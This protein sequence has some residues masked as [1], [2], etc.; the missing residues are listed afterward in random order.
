MKKAVTE[1]PTTP[2][3]KSTQR[4]LLVDGTS[5]CYRA[6]YAIRNL[7]NSKGEPT[8]AIYGFI[9]MIRKLVEEMVPDYLAIAFDRKEPTFRHQRFKDYKAHRKPMP[10]DLVQQLEPIKNYCR[11]AGF[12]IFEEPGYEAD[13]LLGTL[14]KKGEKEKFDVFIVTGDKDFLQ[15]VSGHIKILNPHKEGLLYDTEA[16]RNRFDGIGPEKV[17]DIL[18]LMGDASDN[19][20]GVPGIGEKTALKLIQEFGTVE[21][22]LKHVT[23]LPSKSQQAVLQENAQI[24]LLSKELAT[25]DTEVPLRFSWPGLVPQKSDAEQ[26]ME[27]YKR[28]EFRSLLKDITPAGETRQAERRYEIIT[29]EKGFSRLAAKLEKAGAFSFDT[30]TTHED[31]MRAHLVGMSFSC[32]EFHAAYVPISSPNHAGTGIAMD[33]ALALIQPLLENENIKKCGQNIKYDWI[34]M[35]R[36]GVEI[37]GIDFDTMVASYLL[38]P[39]KLNHNL[40]DISL[41]YLGVRKI[42]TSALIGSG[43]NSAKKRSGSAANSGG[44]ITMAEVP[45]EKIAEYA[46]EDA[47]C[48]FRLKALFQA[49]LQE[50]NLTR[51]FEQVEMPLV[52]VLAKMEM[53]G[54]M[55]DT[56]LLAELSERFEK[57]L[58]RLTQEIY[59]QAGEEF[60]INSTKQLADILFVKLHLPVI[61]RTKTGYSTDVEVLEKLALGHELP[62][63]LLDYR[64]KSKLKST[65]LDALPAMIHPETHRV[66]ASFN[67]TVTATGRLS[68][69]EPN[70]QNIPIRT[71]EGRLIRKAFIPR[72]HPNPLAK[73]EGSV[74]GRKILAADYSQIE[75]RILAHLSEDP[76]LVKAFQEDRDIHKFTAT[77]LY[78]TTEKDVTREMR[79]VAKTINFSIIYG[80]TAFGLSHDLGISVG[81]A[82]QFIKNYFERYKGIKDYLEGQKEEARKKGFLVT[83]LG[84]RSYF[85][86]IQSKNAN[87]RQFAER[88]AI[89]APIQGSAAD[90]IKLAMIAIQRR[91]DGTATQ[92]LMIIQ[93]HDELVFDVVESE[94]DSVTDLVKTEMESAY[95][96][97]V[98]LRVDIFTGD[99]WYK[100]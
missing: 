90:L 65:Y 32:E 64:E 8:N 33:K 34:V 37:R 29:D 62:K 76:S 94:L 15:L 77:L 80:K 43:K 21:N 51:L 30:E 28:F 3:K 25:L 23:R 71:E 87:I 50:Q 89:N 67:Q 31:P 99:S 57:E 40:D 73:G 11:N 97:S 58:G 72:P 93:V 69:S 44:Q 63:L 10:E 78:G 38:N 4:L 17:T 20:P 22:L 12:A 66:H 79:N 56:P 53:A 19:I 13:D 95:K 60:N 5:F 84:R 7:S 52:L 59:K 70:L 9:T 1:A 54:V 55:L 18:A 81:E 14:A 27:F 47:D 82:D 91:L 88:A 74:R 100:N 92:S 98:P 49:K 86:D 61:K 35:R 45:L 26:L 24:A 16:V 75:L 85:P 42:P 83:L 48:V 68:S 36:A 2:R 39:L 96:L 41:E 46:A 6:Y